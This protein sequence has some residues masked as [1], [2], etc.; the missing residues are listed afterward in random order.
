MQ[1]LNKQRSSSSST[2]SSSSKLSN[3]SKSSINY[4]P[5]RDLYRSYLGS[6]A[7]EAILNGMD[8]ICDFFTNVAT[9][10]CQYKNGFAPQD[11]DVEE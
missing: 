7:D 10:A 5:K 3:Y 8:V 2:P 1:T 6:T 9:H 11:P 4:Q